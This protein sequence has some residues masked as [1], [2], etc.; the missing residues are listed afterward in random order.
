M[1]YN[2]LYRHLAIEVRPSEALQ[3]ALI[4]KGTEPTSPDLEEPSRSPLV[5]VEIGSSNDLDPKGRPAK[6]WELHYQGADAMSEAIMASVW[7]ERERAVVDGQPGLT[8][9]GYI[10][11]VRDLLGG[12]TLPSAPLGLVFE[13]D[14][15]LTESVAGFEHLR[16]RVEADP[17]TEYLVQNGFLRVV[18]GRGRLSTYGASLDQWRAILTWYLKHG[19]TVVQGQA[20]AAW[21]GELSDN[22]GL[23]T[24]WLESNR[25]LLRRDA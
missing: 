23:T 4:G 24:L 6:A 8:A 10:A 9:E 18:D 19:T 22:V 5:F 25:G 17:F 15:R 21:N 2:I 16:A 20:L 12:A 13:L 7:I 3:H 14:G 1:S 11:M